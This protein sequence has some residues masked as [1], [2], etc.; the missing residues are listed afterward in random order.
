MLER[1]F[2]VCLFVSVSLSCSW[3][4]HKFT[5]YSEKSLS[6]LDTMT[7]NSTNIT[8]NAEVNSVAFPH[9]L[10]THASAA[11]AE[12]RLGFM[13]QVLEEVVVVLEEDQSSVSWEKNPVEHFLNLLTKQVE[14]L[15]SCITRQSHKKMNKKLHMYFKRLSRNIKEMGRTAEAWELVRKEIKLHLQRVHLLAASLITTY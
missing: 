8:E 10:Y 1:I 7:N 4:D 14:G 13:A 5:Q 3:M 15:R 12:D 11:S 6:L 9:H 2:F